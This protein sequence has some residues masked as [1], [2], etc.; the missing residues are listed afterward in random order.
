[1]DGEHDVAAVVNGYEGHDE[2]HFTLLS[3]QEREVLK[4]ET[5]ENQCSGTV[6][7]TFG[8]LANP[9][10]CGKNVTMASY[11]NGRG[12]LLVPYSEK[13]YVTCRTTGG[14]RTVTT[15]ATT[16]TTHTHTPLL[17]Q[18]TQTYEVPFNPDDL[19]ETPATL[20]VCSSFE[21]ERVLNSLRTCASDISFVVLKRLVDVKRLVDG[22]VIT[23]MSFHE[24]HIIEFVERRAISVV[25]VL[26]SFLSNYRRIFQRVAW[27]RIVVNN[28]FRNKLILNAF[29]SDEFIRRFF[30]VLQS[31]PEAMCAQYIHNTVSRVSTPNVRLG[32]FDML[33]KSGTLWS[34]MIRTNNL[35]LSIDLHMNFQRVEAS[36]PHPPPPHT[37]LVRVAVLEEKCIQQRADKILHDISFTNYR[38]ATQRAWVIDEAR[39]SLDF[40]NIRGMQT[41]DDLQA[42]LIADVEAMMSRA[43]PSDDVHGFQGKLARLQRAPT[44]P[45]ECPVCL[46]SSTA[47][48]TPVEEGEEEEEEESSTIG[49]KFVTIRS[50]HH[51]LCSTCCA[52]LVS[53]T[54]PCVCPNCRQDFNAL[55]VLVST[56]D[57]EAEANTVDALRQAE[58]V[59]YGFLESRK[60]RIVRSVRTILSGSSNANVI[61]TVETV[62]QTRHNLLYDLPFTDEELERV[63]I[64]TLCDTSFMLDANVT[65]PTGMNLCDVTHVVS[66]FPIRDT[67]V[68]ERT[69]IDFCMGLRKTVYVIEI[70]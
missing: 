49:K 57:V 32:V 24:D 54:C 29:T 41:V 2:G 4:M 43:L 40:L 47:T 59:S 66:C 42:F 36:P 15:T 60:D 34:V 13:T 38:N 5:L 22:E 45:L 9:S 70:M 23:A 16:V 27:N 65:A 56:E 3:F 26:D 50:C 48:T 28:I 21:L 62:E 63:W 68:F 55:N 7:T 6:T 53:R 17:V 30:W 31:V 11:L 25:V 44:E 61:V 64:I 69:L 33:Q 39:R 19:P 46:V 51:K 37:P 14:P 35:Q 8:W 20:W 52:I 1:M 10:G 58:I 18:Q 12:S 67:H